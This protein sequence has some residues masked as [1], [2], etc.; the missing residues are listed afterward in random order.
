MKQTMLNYSRAKR[1]FRYDLLCEIR[2]VQMQLRLFRESFE[3]SSFHQATVVVQVPGRR[4]RTKAV[5]RVRE[6][7]L[8]GLLFQLNAILDF[9]VIWLAGRL[10]SVAA[11]PLRIAGK[12]KPN[13]AALL[14]RITGDYSHLPGWKSVNRLRSQANAFKHGGGYVF[15]TDPLSQQQRG[16]FVSVDVDELIKQT[17][18][19]V[20]FLFAIE[21]VTRF[22]PADRSATDLSTTRPPGFVE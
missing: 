22:S 20:R 17:Q 18:D 14:S 8:I 4:H 6:A 10:T 7:A 12:N 21:Q 1:R 3:H 13:L 19:L 15:S 2:C 9:A 16:D 5:H 11:R